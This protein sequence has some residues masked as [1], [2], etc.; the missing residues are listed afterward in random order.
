[1]MRPVVEPIFHILHLS[2][3]FQLCF[4]PRATRRSRRE[5]S[6]VDSPLLPERSDQALLRSLTLVVMSSRRFQE[7][8]PG[9]NLSYSRKGK[10]KLTR[11]TVGGLSRSA[12]WIR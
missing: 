6:R 3:F 5:S 4:Q 10:F 8:A 2:L 9:R 1:M 12:I 7:Q 11:R